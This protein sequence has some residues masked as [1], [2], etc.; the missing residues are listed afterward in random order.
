MFVNPDFQDFA[1]LWSPI[2][3]LLFLPLVTG[4]DKFG[5]E[6]M[7]DKS[8]SPTCGQLL[9]S[10]S[11]RSSP[12]WGWLLLCCVQWDSFNQSVSFMLPKSVSILMRKNICAF[13]DCGIFYISVAGI[14]WVPGTRWTFLVE[15]VFWC[16]WFQCSLLFYQSQLIMNIENLLYFNSVKAYYC[17]FL[18]LT[19]LTLCMEEHQVV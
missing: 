14:L 18:W 19:F 9:I 16:S 8:A 2:L 6:H 3:I 12:V 4:S 7:A 5:W 11:A 10:R 13:Y 17:V 1:L 15:T